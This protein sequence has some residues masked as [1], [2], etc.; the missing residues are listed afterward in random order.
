VGSD[1]SYTEFAHAW[2][3]VLQETERW[4]DRAID[5]P[6]E[7]RRR[8]RILRR[9]RALS[10][11]LLPITSSRATGDVS[12]VNPDDAERDAPPD[13]AIRNGHSDAPHR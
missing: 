7:H 6:A 2:I 5:N 10:N 13:D 1:G 8:F 11:D 9:L 3:R 12:A 4:C